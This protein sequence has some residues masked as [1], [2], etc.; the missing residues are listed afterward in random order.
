M[1]KCARPNCFGCRLL[2]IAVAATSAA[3]GAAQIS[4]DGDGVWA[5]RHLPIL[6]IAH[7]QDGNLAQRILD[8]MMAPTRKLY[9]TTQALSWALHI[10]SALEYLHLRS[11]AVLHRDVKSSNIMLTTED[12]ALVAKLSDFGLHSVSRPGRDG[13]SSRDDHGGREQVYTTCCARTTLACVL[14]GRTD[15][16][17][18]QSPA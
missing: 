4:P 18:F 14:A 2:T 17:C 8:Q 16:F 6:P 11:P 9:T 10:A 12:G 3:V 13:T 15:G 5:R 1:P 7:L